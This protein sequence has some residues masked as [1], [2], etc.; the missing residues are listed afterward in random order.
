MA[1][2]EPTAPNSPTATAVPSDAWSLSRPRLLVSLL[3][4]GAVIAGV[5]SGPPADGVAGI[6]L[7]WGLTGPVAGDPWKWLGAGLLVVVVLRVERLGTSSLLLRRPSGRDLEWVLYAFG[8]VMAWSWLIGALAPQRDNEGVAT[9]AALGVAGALVL[10][11]TAAVTEEVVYRG[12]LAERLGAL[13]GRRA[14]SRWLGAAASLAIFTGPHLVFFG[15]S[16]L[17]HQLPGAL[18]VA[19]V[20]AVRRNLPAAMALHLLINLPIL[21]PVAAAS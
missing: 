16:W 21:I 10:I 7:R 1:D 19:T 12:F 20:A 2:A 18:A 15:L 17:L 8:I 9:I 6:D 3:L 11:V 5:Y 13:L 4:G 14:G